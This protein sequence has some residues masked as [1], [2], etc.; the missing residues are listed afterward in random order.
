MQATALTT[1]QAVA[2]Q[3]AEAARRAALATAGI[4]P[5]LAAYGAGLMDPVRDEADRGAWP[6]FDT[7]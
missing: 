5:W 3:D 7:S 1:C 4:A 6:T 2:E